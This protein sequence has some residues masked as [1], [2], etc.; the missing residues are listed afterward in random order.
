MF[1]AE[2]VH[3]AAVDAP[4]AMAVIGPSIVEDVAERWTDGARRLRCRG[5]FEVR[6]ETRLSHE[7]NGDSEADNGDDNPKIEGL[8]AQRAMR[9]DVARDPRHHPHGEI[10]REL[11]QPQGEAPALRSNQIDL[12]D[13]G[14]RPRHR[15]VRAE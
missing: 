4:R 1:D 14:H 6:V 9:G 13:D 11:V 15:L 2:H 12:H 10:A 5:R 7:Q 8:W 3:A